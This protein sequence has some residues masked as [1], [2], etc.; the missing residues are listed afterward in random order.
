MKR[1]LWFPVLLFLILAL[2]AYVAFT[3]QPSDVQSQTGNAFELLLFL[4]IVFLVN[5]LGNIGAGIVFLVLAVA[6]AL[7]FRYKPWEKPPT[8]S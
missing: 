2:C 4:P 7:L 6:V 8:E 1:D 3:L 5:I